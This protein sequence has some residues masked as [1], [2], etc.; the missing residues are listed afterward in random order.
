MRVH[1]TLK[2]WNDSR[3]FGFVSRDQRDE[4]L[5]VHI[6]AFPRD[7]IRPR[8]GEALSFEIGE[9]AGGKRRAILVQRPGPVRRSPQ[10]PRAEERAKFS[11]KPL[12]PFA[13]LVA[14]AVLA[15]ERFE[16]GGHAPPSKRGKSRLEAARPPEVQTR[17]VEQFRCDS[18]TQCT[19]MTSCAE[20]TYFLK[21]CPGAQ[22]D[23]D[24]DGIPCE[25]QWCGH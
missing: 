3:G 24:H 25:R 18:R 11:L 10:R 4:E 12:A 1:G 14:L 7:G 21:H 22:M 9:A 19:Q 15:Y 20:A 6:S 8:I 5:F 23:G 17:P 16:P 13:A 2:K